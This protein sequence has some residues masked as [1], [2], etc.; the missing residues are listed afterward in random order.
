MSP[1]LVFTY[2]DPSPTGRTPVPILEASICLNCG[3]LIDPAKELLKEA[4]RNVGLG[5]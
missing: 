3:S 2:L 1:F 4:V 5:L